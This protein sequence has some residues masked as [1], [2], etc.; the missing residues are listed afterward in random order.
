MA[1]QDY[2]DY[3]DYLDCWYYLVYP[4]YLFT[5]LVQFNARNFDTCFW[6]LQILALISFHSI[7]PLPFKKKREKK[8]I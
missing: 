2:W 8:I 4:A 6:T 7:S 5:E 3:Q 1:Y